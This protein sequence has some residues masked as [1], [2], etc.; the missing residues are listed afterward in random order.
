VRAPRL[1]IERGEG[2]GVLRVT[3]ELDRSNAGILLEAVRLAARRVPPGAAVELDCSG[4][5]FLDASG[6]ETLVRAARFLAPRRELVVLDPG[7][8]AGELLRLRARTTSLLTVVS[9]DDAL[10]RAS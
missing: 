4:V 3:G 6:S 9:S 7:A 8:L 1:R 5:A 10:P 2:P